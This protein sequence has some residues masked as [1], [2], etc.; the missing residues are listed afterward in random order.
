[1]VSPSGVLTIFAGTGSPGYSGDTGLATA[2]QLNGPT[3][4]FVDANNNVFIADSGNN[5][6]REVAASTLIITTVAGNHT[7]GAGFSGD[8]GAAT[9][10]QLNNPTSVYVDANNDIFI[11]DNGNQVIREVVG[12]TISTIAGTHGVSGFSGNG[13]LATA[14]EFHNPMSVSLD[15]AGNIYIADQGNN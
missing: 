10:A 15:S 7:L 4:V 12:T 6:I 9:S 11:A 5:V 2:A 8:A 3:G 13:G 14:A 1:M